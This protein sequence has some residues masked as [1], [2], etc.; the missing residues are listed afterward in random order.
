MHR[1][2]PQSFELI[3]FVH[4]LDVFVHSLDVFVHS[5]DL[6]KVTHVYPDL[7]PSTPIYPQD[8]SP[9]TVNPKSGNR[10]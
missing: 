4:S 10:G 1:T 2:A 6:Y 7:P 9:Y 8:V 5:L 3:N